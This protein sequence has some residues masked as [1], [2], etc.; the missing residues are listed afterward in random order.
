MLDLDTDEVVYQNRF[1][2]PEDAKRDLK[3]TFYPQGAI[4]QSDFTV[5]DEK[6]RI[7]NGKLRLRLLVFVKMEEVDILHSDAD[8]SGILPKNFLVEFEAKRLQNSGHFGFTVFH[9]S[10]VDS[11]GSNEVYLSIPGSFFHEMGLRVPGMGMPVKFFKINLQNGHRLGISL[12]GST[13][14][15]HIDGKLVESGGVS[16][17]I[18]ES[19]DDLESPSFHSIS[20][21]IELNESLEG[22]IHLSAKSISALGAPVGDLYVA[23]SGNKATGDGSLENPFT[24]LQSAIDLASNGQTIVVSPGTY[25]GPGNRELD[26]KGKEIRLLSFMATIETIVDCGGKGD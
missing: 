18:E 12:N 17:Y 13:V 1:S 24:T 25:E 16:D 22:K 20:G 8:Y 4:D 23:T 5:D 11:L 2:T 6:N 26:F 7:V 9:R 21:H 19:S 14:G 10:P 3:L 15:F